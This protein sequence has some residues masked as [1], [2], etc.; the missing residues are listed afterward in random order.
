MP[1]GR[2]CRRALEGPHG[3]DQAQPGGSPTGPRQSPVPARDGTPTGRDAGASEQGDRGSV[4]SASHLIWLTPV[5]V[6]LTLSTAFLL[7]QP[8]LLPMD[9]S[10]IHVVYG[11]NLAHT[12][13]L[14]YNL[15]EFAGIG[16]TSILWVLLIAGLV[17]VGLSGLV[18]VRVL[19]V[20]SLALMSVATSFLAQR[21]VPRVLPRAPSWLAWFAGLACAFSGNLVWF[22]MSGMETLLFLGL[23]LLTIELYARDCWWGVGATA[24]LAALTRLEGGMLV[25]AL[26]TVQLLAS[27]RGRPFPWKRLPLPAAF[28]AGELLPWLAYLHD[29][30]GHWLP[31]SFGGKKAVQMAATTEI[32]G[33][34]G[35]LGVLLSVKPVIYLGLWLAY[36]A[37]WVWGLGYGFP[38]YVSV[39]QE[40]GGGGIDLWLPAVATLLLVVAPLTLRGIAACWR[41][42]R[43]L[44]ADVD[45]RSLAVF[46]LWLVLH[47]ASYA[48]LFP[49]L[50]TTSRYQ[51]VNHL[52]L[53]LLPLLGLGSLRRETLRTL[54]GAAMGL[55]LLTNLCFW[56]ATY[57]ANLRHMA[58]VRM[59]AAAWIREAPLAARVAAF[60]I[61]ALRW[62]SGRPITDLGGLVDA[63][64]VEYQ[65]TDRVAEFLAK[66][67]VTHLAIPSAHSSEPAAFFDLLTF[68]RIRTDPK[69]SL[70]EVARFEGD[71]Q[72]WR[73]G[74]GPT[75]NY[76]PSVVVYRVDYLG[77]P[78]QGM[79]APSWNTP[80]GDG[81]S[82]SD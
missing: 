36:A 70:R 66:H 51:A 6:A 23:A 34:A 58:G 10:Y 11:E 81:G 69:L 75:F 80:V 64:Y 53:W 55:L 42:R 82:A 38:P 5:V 37:S 8:E 63:D 49:S 15:G 7:P 72:E 65:K 13:K 20:A 19:G 76:M 1:E 22:G 14:E 4:G 30:T 77:E 50:G 12:G 2:A 33:R 54:A 67:G 29:R 45:G 16:S 25:V 26:L 35:A 74:A 18:A 40:V 41:A 9:D 3:G 73:R 68:L 56:R 24:G 28:L 17:K 60:D 44:L 31:T 48:V 39:G 21:W 47:N 78:P 43:G 57:A 46:G 61:G 32:V 27:R 71:Y 52:V 79:R 59:E 62:G